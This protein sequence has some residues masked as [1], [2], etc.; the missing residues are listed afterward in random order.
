MRKGYC[1][2]KMTSNTMNN[3]SIIIPAYNEE[4]GI[5]KT[6]EELLEYEPL[7]GAEII[8]IDDGS[9]DS[10]HCILDCFEKRI[11]II[12]HKV[13]RG[14]GSAIASGVKKCSREI[15]AW[16][17]ADGQHRPCD[18]VNVIQKLQENNLDYCIGVRGADSYV[19]KNRVLGKLV[20]K[21]VVK[22]ASNGVDTDFNSGLR[23]FRREVLEQYI[24]LLPERFGAS[25]VTTLL[26]QEG[27]WSGD[28]VGIKVQKRTGKS[29]VK[30]IKDGMRTIILIGNVVMLFHPMRFFGPLGI[31]F[32]LLGCVYGVCEALT[33]GMGIPTLAAI[34]IIFGLQIFFWGITIAQ[35]S[36]MR[37]ENLANVRL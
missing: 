17:D 27:N 28:E 1:K 23:A 36:K 34:V 15:V 30:Q 3:V 24:K 11:T 20:L 19:E 29:S 25:T 9:T 31:F 16:Y 6:I 13:N 21:Y 32:V 22:W 8:V 35:I 18:L 4:Q 2:I 5:K 7:Y 10:T 14:Y 37:K 26:M 12:Q 33:K